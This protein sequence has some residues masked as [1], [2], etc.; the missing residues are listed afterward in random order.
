MH[1]R[2]AAAHREG[3]ADHLGNLPA[4]AAPVPVEPVTEDV[5]VVAVM[6]GV[7]G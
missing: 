6:L 1:G 3:D 7:R 4:A 5:V 2:G